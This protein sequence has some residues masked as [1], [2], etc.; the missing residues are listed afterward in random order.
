MDRHK[1]TGST[2]I[3]TSSAAETPK[4]NTDSDLAASTLLKQSK[5]FPKKNLKKLK[6]VLEWRVKK[7]WGLGRRAFEIY[8]K[9]L[10]KLDDWEENRQ[11]KVGGLIGSANQKDD[12]EIQT[13]KR[14][15]GDSAGGAGLSGAVKNALGE[16][17]IG[18]WRCLPQKQMLIASR[19]LF[20]IDT[21]PP[22]TREPSVKR[23]KIAEIMVNAAATDS[24][25]YLH[26]TASRVS[27]H[28]SSRSLQPY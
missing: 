12:V 25:T 11:R 20:G 22:L 15:K 7:Q 24:V 19:L 14:S 18:I 1:A 28:P 17:L 27:T 8:K 2:T 23:R 6:K 10:I 5:D 13:E 3:P 16:S 4:T 9:A 26:S 21:L